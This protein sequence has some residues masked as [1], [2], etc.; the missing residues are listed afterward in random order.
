[1]RH[2]QAI[3]NRFAGDIENNAGSAAEDQRDAC[4]IFPPSSH[5]RDS[6]PDSLV[7]WTNRADVPAS[8]WTDQMLTGRSNESSPFVA[9][10]DSAAFLTSQKLH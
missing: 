3:E 8:N 4:A 9:R 2:K 1:M 6:C 5:P 7:V 10:F